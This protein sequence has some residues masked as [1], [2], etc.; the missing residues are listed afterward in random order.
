MFRHL[1]FHW[2]MLVPW[3]R[4]VLLLLVAL[5]G[6]A[7]AAY[8]RWAS[9]SW[10]EVPGTVEDYRLVPFGR[11]N[12]ENNGFSFS[13]F[14]NG[15]FYAGELAVTRR[16]R[17]PKNEEDMQRLYPRGSKIRVRYKTNDP[18]VYVAFPTE[19]P[20]KSVYFPPRD[21]PRK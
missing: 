16:Q 15:E 2:D 18:S 19:V 20:H 6:A 8:R 5:F 7:V 21:D 17:F 11:Q 3:A 14:A 10:P 1:H 12:P 9:F 4:E 13:Y